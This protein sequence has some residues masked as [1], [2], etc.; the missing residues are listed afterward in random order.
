MHI[1]LFDIAQR[2]SGMREIE[3]EMNNPAI[4]SML[5]LDMRWPDSDE[6]P[7]CSGF[8]NY[9]AWLLR[10]P[11][12]KSLRARSW[13]TVGHPV[14]LEQAVVGFDVVVLSRGASPP[15]PEVLDAPGHVG[16]FA[17]LE[18]P[19]VYLLGGN[20]NN[21][22]NVSPYALDRVLGVRRLRVETT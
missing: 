22:V 2:F 14:T 4:L 8:A 15:G 12:S 6:V 3:G 10:L 9:C 13:L 11:R 21:E 17:G 20:Q 1:T 5:Q 18:V 19:R 16:V 7:W